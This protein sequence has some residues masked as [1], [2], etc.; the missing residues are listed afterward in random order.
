[1]LRGQLSARFD[2]MQ[3]NLPAYQIFGLKNLLSNIL[4]RPNFISYEINALPKG[5]VTRLRKKGITVLGWTVRSEEQKEK[6]GRYC[7]TVIFENIR[8]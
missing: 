8:P 2:D 1:V 5:V 3:E 6:A 7:D 4:A